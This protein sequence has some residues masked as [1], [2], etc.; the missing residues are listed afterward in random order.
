MNSIPKFT[1][2]IFPILFLLSACSWKEYFI[3]YNESQAP[4]HIEYK[5]NP[6]KEFHIFTQQPRIQKMRKKDINWSENYTYKD[7]DSTK[8]AIKVI[9]PPNSALI[10]G[11]LS[12]DH[13]SSQKQNFINGRNFNLEQINIQQANKTISITPI[14]FDS[15]FKIQKGNIECRI[16]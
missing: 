14:N 9:L 13:Y 16:K 12:N 10:F 2:I 6:S 7:L 8:N 11:E 1:L 15:I 5:L 4:I 3:I